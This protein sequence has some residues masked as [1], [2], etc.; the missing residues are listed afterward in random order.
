MRT[1]NPQ[2]GR[3]LA[4]LAVLSLAVSGLTAAG[5]APASAATA[6]F[7]ASGSASV[8]ALDVLRVP[9]LPLPG[10][11]DLELGEVG[12]TVDSSKDQRASAS[13]A[14]LGGE[15]LLGFEI[16]GL[17]VASQQAT[18]PTGAPVANE[19][20]SRTTIPLSVP[21]L[22]DLGVSTSSA[23]ARWA[24]DNQCLPSGGV[25]TRAETSTAG[26]SVLPI[27]LPGLGSFALAELPDTAGVQHGIRVEETTK[28]KGAVVSAAT[29]ST[30]D[31]TLFDDNVGVKVLAPPKLTARATG[32]AGGAKVSYTPAV[33]GITGPGGA[34]VP[35]PESGTLPACQLPAN[36]LLTLELSLPG[37]A[38]VVQSADG[39]TASASA[40]TLHLKL[41]LAGLTI[42]EVDLLPLTVSATAPA[43]GVDCA[44]PDT[45]G[46]GL[47]DDQEKQLGTDPTKPDTDGDG[48]KD[49][50]EVND[51]KTDPL[52]PDTDGDGLTDG[53][54]VTGSAN[55]KY[56]G[57]P[58]DPTK[59]D[60]DGD[61]LSDGREVKE[62]GTDPNTADTDGDGFDDGTEIDDG[63]DPLDPTDP[64]TDPGR[65][66]SDG[67]GLE[68][69]RELTIGTNPFDP[70]TDGDGL[71][72]GQE[73]S[74][75]ANTKYGKRPT[76]PTQADT[77]GDGIGDRAE[78][79]GVR[80]NKL[81]VLAKGKPKKIGLV[82]LNPNKADTDGD[83]LKD[84][85]E[86]K[87]KKVNLRIKAQGGRTIVM[88]KLKSNPLVKDTDRD[89]LN[90][91]VEATGSRNK[92]YGKQPSDPAHWDT[93]R[94]GV[95]D[96]VE[97]RGNYNPSDVRSGPG[98][99]R[100]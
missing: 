3:G 91:K 27:S 97:V 28:G 57:K 34:E 19:P 4:A 90:D 78:I 89:G 21:A 25:L 36:P 81:V 54:E 64:G 75:G 18:S 63:T 46:D 51:H 43:S 35:I 48:L 80:M 49:G 61:G 11:T 5:T 92:R 53:Q 86:V 93:D 20:V 29:A 95:S 16:P 88:K 12:S 13:A 77:D 59:P 62:T 58:T 2:R 69:L 1:P 100:G 73:V 10:V 74:G 17:S 85:V 55:T 70:D 99:P 87:G 33:L 47:S 23:L 68:D 32:T 71:T 22:L 37:T 14:G 79:K 7:S 66:D 40:V 96:G 65:L 98:K 26:A 83:G 56:D 45:D 50:A 44:A 24:G 60:T 6:P 84:G 8:L 72:D 15:G 82:R 9:A 52:K 31:L 41:A 76:D 94:G 38:D 42:A 67:D 30:V 39:R